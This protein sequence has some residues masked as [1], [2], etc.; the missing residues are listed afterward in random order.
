MTWPID[1]ISFST[2]SKIAKQLH[3]NSASSFG[4]TNK[5]PLESKIKYCSFYK[6]WS[7]TVSCFSQSLHLDRFSNFLV[8]YPDIAV[9]LLSCHHPKHSLK[10]PLVDH[11]AFHQSFHNFHPRYSQ[12]FEGPPSKS[13]HRSLL[14]SGKIKSALCF[15]LLSNSL[16]TF[17]YSFDSIVKNDAL[18]DHFE[19]EL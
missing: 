1:R 2:K 5:P 14:V 18:S 3:T 10:S 17:H 9:A 12:V 16:R 13:L 19:V 4:G 15:V 11:L 6:S 8:M 7:R